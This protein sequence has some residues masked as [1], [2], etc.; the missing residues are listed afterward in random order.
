MVRIAKAL[1]MY[2]LTLA[3]KA[4]RIENIR[5]IDQTQD[6]VV[7][8]AGLLFCCQILH[9]IADDI[10]GGLQRRCR[11]RNAAGCLRIDTGGV[12]DKVGIQ[13]A[14]LDLIDGQIAGQLIQNGAD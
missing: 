11:E 6:I 8:H 12:V 2:D 7:G 3:Q 1:E 9:Q 4:D 14:L 5:V 13:T 10:A